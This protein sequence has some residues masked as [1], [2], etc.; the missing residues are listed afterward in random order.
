[1]KS[2][3]RRQAFRNLPGSL[4]LTPAVPLHSRYEPGRKGILVRS[5]AATIDSLNFAHSRN[6]LCRIMANLFFHIEQHFTFFLDEDFTNAPRYDRWA[7]ERNPEVG[8]GRAGQGTVG[9]G[10]RSLGS[11][12]FA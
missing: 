10:G 1:M 4:G 7:S 5:P 6:P 11:G 8:E 9:S 12:M 2:A 3:L